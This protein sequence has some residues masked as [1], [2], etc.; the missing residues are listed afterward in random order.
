MIV[1]ILVTVVGIV[2][3]TSDVHPR[4][5]YAPN[6][7]VQLVLIIIDGTNDDSNTINLNYDYSIINVSM[8]MKRM[9][10]KLLHLEK[11]NW[12]MKKDKE[13]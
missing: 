5:A 10:M 12:N 3:A 1:P 11:D 8:I 13:L 2:T 9:M 4:K 6:E 7:K